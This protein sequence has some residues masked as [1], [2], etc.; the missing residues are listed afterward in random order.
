MTIS[1]LAPDTLDVLEA[2]AAG[3]DEADA[4]SIVAHMEKAGVF[5]S[6][7]NRVHSAALR[8]AAVLDFQGVALPSAV[9]TL[10]D[11]KADVEVKE[12]AISVFLKFA[13]SPGLEPGVS[14]CAALVALTR[15]DATRVAALKALETLVSRNFRVDLGAISEALDVATAL[16]AALRVL[17]RGAEIGN[18][19]REISDSVRDRLLRLL[20][21][22]EGETA[23][24][25]VKLAKHFW[26]SDDNF[27]QVSGAQKKAALVD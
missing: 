16:R 22:A 27:Q 7:Q 6:P 26:A 12:A 13:T 8:V 19:S 14:G 4:A 23:T 5:R 2:T 15:T 9:E 10:W 24:E 11:A 3:F 25:A 1:S 17:T 18:F 20:R 21:V